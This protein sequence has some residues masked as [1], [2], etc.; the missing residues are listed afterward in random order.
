M[1]LLFF[2]V[3][4][5]AE[6]AT[7]RLNPGDNKFSLKSGGHDRTYLVHVTPPANASQRFR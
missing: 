4:G 5:A 1:M 3:A 2:A 7:M 6:S